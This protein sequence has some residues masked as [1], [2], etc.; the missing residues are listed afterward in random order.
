MGAPWARYTP[1][2][3][4]RQD[5]LFGSSLLVLIQ[6]HG[7][8][9]DSCLAAH[10]FR[11]VWGVVGEWTLCSDRWPDSWSCGSLFPQSDTGLSTAVSWLRRCGIYNPDLCYKDVPWHR[12]VGKT[13][14]YGR[15]T[16]PNS[17]LHLPSASMLVHLGSQV[18]SSGLATPRWGDGPTAQQF[19]GRSPSCGMAIVY[20]N[21]CW[22]RVLADVYTDA[23]GKTPVPEGALAE[24]PLAQLR[25]L[26]P[27]CPSEQE[28]LWALDGFI[29][30][31]LYNE[32]YPIIAHILAAV[33]DVTSPYRR[34][35]YIFH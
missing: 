18:F 10:P 25:G 21:A 19:G 29:T 16:G 6:K 15:L 24:C 20:V 3:A 31:C 22:T 13:V 28:F 30:V 2:G 5:P 34:A 11:A 33:L 8:L 32:N 17:M 7:G 12:I 1:L 27:L 9:L 4:P 26:Y 23:Y 35:E 14:G